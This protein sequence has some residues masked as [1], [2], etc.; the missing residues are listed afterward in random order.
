MKKH[1]VHKVLFA[2]VAFSFTAFVFMN[3]YEVVFNKDVVLAKSV[4][5]FV[6]QGAIN[7]ATKDF[8]IEITS[9]TADAHPALENMDRI[10]FPATKTQLKLEEARRIDGMWYQRPSAVHYVG[11]NK[12]QFGVAVDYLLYTTKS[13][14]TLPA[15][16]QIEQ[17]MEARV[18]YGSGAVS[19]FEVAEKKVFPHDK[20]PLLSKSE[21]R[22]MLF[23]VDDPDQGVYYGFS[24]VLRK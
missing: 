24:L 16:E 18:F 2:M 19:T 12:N 15:P 1:V 22:Q 3:T 14:R 10:E 23:I 17:G 8:D 9:E 7:T 11:L 5:Q 20:S 13:W 6:P 4:T 21:E